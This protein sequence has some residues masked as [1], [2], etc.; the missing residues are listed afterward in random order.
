[1]GAHSMVGQ[2]T[3]REHADYCLN[4]LGIRV[5]ESHCQLIGKSGGDWHSIGPRW[6]LPVR[7]PHTAEQL[8]ECWGDALRVTAY[9]YNEEHPSTDL[10]E[11]LESRPMCHLTHPPT[12]KN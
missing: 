12:H 10:L 9:Q 11:R 5:W 4:Q 1:M 7:V 2:E 3:G 8:A 6:M